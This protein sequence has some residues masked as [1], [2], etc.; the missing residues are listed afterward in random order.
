[1]KGSVN[2]VPLTFK[3][4]SMTFPNGTHAVANASVSIGS[5]EFVSIV[6]PSG[7]GKSTLLRI[8]AGLVEPSTGYVSKG[9]VDATKIGFIFQEPTLMPWATARENVALPLN[10]KNLDKG[11]QGDRIDEALSLVGLGEFANAYPRELSGGMKMRVSCARALVGSPDIL[12]L[13]EPFAALDEFTRAQLNDDLLSLWEAQKWTALFV[14]HSIQEAAY[15]SD[16][17]VVMSDRPGRIVAE[18]EVP[19]PHPRNR[20]LRASHAFVDFTSEISSILA[21]SAKQDNG[22]EAV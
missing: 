4:V 21:S 12:L 1:M 3:N 8:A 18:R 14:T 15:L 19:F 6:G 9:D 20:D 17:I 5:G 22:T 13:D 7:C 2:P 16:R 10:I 11:K